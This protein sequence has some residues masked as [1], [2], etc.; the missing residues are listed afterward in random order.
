MSFVNW[1][2]DQRLQTER[3]S[4]LGTKE[5]CGLQKA[6][7]SFLHLYCLPGVWV[8]F[9]P[10]YEMPEKITL[11]NRGREENTITVAFKGTGPPN[12]MGP[13]TRDQPLK[14]VLSTITFLTAMPLTHGP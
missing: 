11:Q 10:L 5:T 1:N 8:I 13:Q 12:V 4:K 14:M 9:P 7:Y 6:D 2:E 3:Q